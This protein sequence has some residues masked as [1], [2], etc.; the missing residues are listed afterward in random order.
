M[1]IVVI[2]LGVVDIVL[3]MSDIALSWLSLPWP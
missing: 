2:A 1:F 3:A